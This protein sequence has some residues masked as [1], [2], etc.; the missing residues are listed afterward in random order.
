MVGVEYKDF[1]FAVA[2]QDLATCSRLV[3]FQNC[4]EVIFSYLSASV[5]N[6]GR[7]VDVLTIG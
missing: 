1:T 3:S 7:V 5:V 6:I 2:L 4:K